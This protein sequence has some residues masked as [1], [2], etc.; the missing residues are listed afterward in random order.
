MEITAVVPVPAVLTTKFEPKNDKAVSL[1]F[2]AS[3]VLAFLTFVVGVLYL[4]NNPPPH[5]PPPTAI[6]AW[7]PKVVIL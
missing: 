4:K 2:V 7:S 1:Q 5:L 3:Y 6:A